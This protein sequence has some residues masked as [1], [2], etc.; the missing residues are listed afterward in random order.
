MMFCVAVCE[1][2][3]KDSPLASITNVPLIDSRL[4]LNSVAGLREL[5]INIF[6]ANYVYIQMFV[7]PTQSN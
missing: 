7:A 1:T 6:I 3:I 2:F 5:D 4:N